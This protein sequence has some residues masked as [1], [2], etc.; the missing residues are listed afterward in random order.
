MVESA[1]TPFR[2][3]VPERPL[4]VVLYE[5][6]ATLAHDVLVNKDFD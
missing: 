6:H 3:L 1:E 2:L 5:N 4:E